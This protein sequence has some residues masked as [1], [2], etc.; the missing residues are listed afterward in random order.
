M[1]ISRR[2]AADA[3]Y[4]F[5]SLPLGVVTFVLLVPLFAAGMGT[6]VVFLGFPLLALCLLIARGFADLQRVRLEHVLGHP[7]PRPVYRPAPADAGWFRRLTTPMRTGQSWL[8][9]LHGILNFPISIITFVLPLTWWAGALGGLTYSFWG[10]FLPQG[11]D[12]HNIVVEILFGEDTWQNQ[13]LFNLY[14]GIFFLLTV[15]FVQRA[16][17]AL[18]AGFARMLLTRVAEMQGRI[19]TLTASRA[20]AVSA[21]ATA[22]RRLERDIHDGPQQR[23]IR[24]AMELSRA[25][26]Q[27]ADDPDAAAQTLD[28]ALGQARETLDELRALSRGIAPPILAD[29]GLHAALTTL[30]SRSTVPVDLNLQVEERLPAAVENVL[31][32]TAAEALANVAKHSEATAAELTLARR[33]GRVYLMVGDNGTGGAHPAK[34]HGLAGLGDR[35]H[36]VDGDLAVDSPAGG[37]TIV[38]AEVPV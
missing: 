15:Y 14:A 26:R 7:V 32:F 24:L 31:Y 19:D 8:D 21:E 25:K 11:D 23:L 17:V 33:D 28:E 30:A 36:A 9:L 27:L 13:V 16:A 35:L 3:A 10:R 20:A 29:R 1:R 4:T 18:H 22:L 34:G 37:P 38:I 12:D 6:L 2:L 5:L